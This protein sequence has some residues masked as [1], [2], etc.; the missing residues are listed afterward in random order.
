MLSGYIFVDNKSGDTFINRQM[1]WTREAAEEAL[2]AWM[3]RYDGVAKHDDG[4]YYD[5]NG[6]FVQAYVQEIDLP[7]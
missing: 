3:S 1:F 5:D 7:E 2:E 6:E 4:F